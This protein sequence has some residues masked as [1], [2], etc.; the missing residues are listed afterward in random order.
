M[1]KVFVAMPYGI[2]RGILKRSD[3]Q[4]TK[5]DFD[6]VFTQVLKPLIEIEGQYKIVLASQLY[7]GGAIDVQ[8]IREINETDIFVAD[9]TFGNPNVLYELGIAATLKEKSPLLIAYEKYELPFDVQGYRVFKYSLDNIKHHN[10]FS[11]ELKNA[12]R[13]TY[14]EPSPVVKALSPTHVIKVLTS[15]EVK[16]EVDEKRMYESMLDQKQFYEAQVDIAFYM[17]QINGCVNTHE[18]IRLQESIQS[19]NIYI[20]FLLGKKLRESGLFDKALNSFKKALGLHSLEG[21]EIDQLVFSKDIHSSILREI[22]FIFGKKQEYK[23]SEKYFR[24]AYDLNHY[25]VELLLNFGNQSKNSNRPDDA[26]RLFLEAYEIDK[27]YLYTIASLASLAIYQ[28]HIEEAKKYYDEIRLKGEEQKYNV[29]IVSFWLFINLGEAYTFLEME[30]KAIEM[31][32]KAFGLKDKPKK[33]DYD[34][35]KQQLIEFVNKGNDRITEIS[36]KIIT[37]IIDVNRP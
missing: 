31:Y 9:V 11:N 21:N 36:S 5:I 37:D 8:F 32:K 20:L 15:D 28:K 1:K 34:S 23:L 7:R 17:D 29:P 30:E 25:D 35:I 33:S 26:K 27:D 12:L 10:Q 4:L 14:H 19:S 22:G 24:L 3:D 18:L 6:F 16:R 2:H 13:E